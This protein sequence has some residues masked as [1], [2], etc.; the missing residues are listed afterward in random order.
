M[1]KF[2][3]IVFFNTTFYIIMLYSIIGKNIRK[4]A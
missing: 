2:I 4:Y 3:S 1:N